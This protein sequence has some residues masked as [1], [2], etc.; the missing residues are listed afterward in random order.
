MVAI[1]NN[2]TLR[3]NIKVLLCG[4]QTIEIKNLLK[5]KVC[6]NLKKQKKIIVIKKFLNLK[7]ESEVFSASDLIWIVYKNSSMGSSGILFLAKKAKTP[8]ITT[9]FGLPYWF[10]RKY[11]LGPSIDLKDRKNTIKIL[12]NLSSKK[13]FYNSYKKYIK[14]REKELCKEFYLMI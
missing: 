7:E 12:N 4:Q 14:T 3:K 10:N 6:L 5:N 9:K 11:N 1:L 13:K 2:K 8:I